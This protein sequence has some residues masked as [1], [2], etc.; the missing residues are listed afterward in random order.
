MSSNRLIYDKCSQEEQNNRNTN[1]LSWILDQNRFNSD[2]QCM[3]EGLVSGNITGINDLS[4]RVDVETLLFG[5]DNK[6]NRDCKAPKNLTK[7]SSLNTSCK[8]FDMQSNEVQAHGLTN[9]RCETIQSNLDLNNDDLLEKEL[10]EI[11]N[12]NQE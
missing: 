1:Q 6:A 11:E 4:Q 2:K 5:I 9:K 7:P 8:F 12:Y 3:A 10:R